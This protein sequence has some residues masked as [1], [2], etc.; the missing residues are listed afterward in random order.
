MEAIE[1]YPPIK[2]GKIYRF[3]N[4]NG[5]S[6]SLYESKETV[7]VPSYSKSFLGEIKTDNQLFILLE[8]GRESDICFGDSYK[9]LLIDSK[10]DFGWIGLPALRVYIEEVSS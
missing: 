4:M 1:K 10:F 8:R 6:I 9:I 3:R 7:G 2:F 5:S